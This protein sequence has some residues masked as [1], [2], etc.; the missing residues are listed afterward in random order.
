MK[1]RLEAVTIKAGVLPRSFYP[2]ELPDMPNPAARRGDGWTVV[3]A[4]ST[5]MGE[6]VPFGFIWKPGH[7]A[8]SHV[9]PRAGILW[10][11]SSNGR[12]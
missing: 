3:F 9:E 12:G 7:S 4:R 10:L 5:P 8:A 1:R 6:P 2:A 11:L